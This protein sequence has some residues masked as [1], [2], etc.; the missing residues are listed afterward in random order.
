MQALYANIAVVDTGAMGCG[1]A[2]IAAQAGS[3]VTLYD[4]QPS[5]IAAAQQSIVEQ[6]DR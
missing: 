3:T 6:W 5:A 2:Q 4:Q 1:I